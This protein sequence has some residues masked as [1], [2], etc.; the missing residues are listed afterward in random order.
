[1]GDFLR[2]TF[3]CLLQGVLMVLAFGFM[4]MGV[5]ACGSNQEGLGGFFVVLSIL[6]F[7]AEGGVRYWLGH[8][9]RMR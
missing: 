1:M 7:A 3:G 9:V 6:C 8:V 4:I 5:V 2:G